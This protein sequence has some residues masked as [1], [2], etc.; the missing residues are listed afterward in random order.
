MMAGGAMAR[1]TSGRVTVP[2]T[3]RAGCAGR[4]GLAKT[5]L[6]HRMISRGRC[7]ISRF[8]SERGFVRKSAMAIETAATT[9]DAPSTSV[10]KSFLEKQDQVE[11]DPI[12]QLEISERYWRGMKKSK[13]TKGPTVVSRIHSDAPEEISRGKADF[14]VCVCGGNLG[15]AIALALQRRGHRVL[16]LER[17][18]LRGRK[19]EWNASRK[20]L[21]ALVSVGLL[22]EAE[23]EEAIVSEFNP[24]RVG[25]K[26]GE[27]VWVKDVLNIGVAP[28]RLIRSMKTRFIE[29]GGTVREL[30]EFRSAEIYDDMAVLKLKNLPPSKEDEAALT[31]SLDMIDANKP[32]AIPYE[33]SLDEEE[34]ILTEFNGPER[35]TCSL[36][37]DS[38]G[39]F[40]PIVKQLR[41]GTKP[42]SILLVVGGCIG[43]GIP[44]LGHSDVLA[45]ISG[46]ERDMQFFWETFPAKDGD[47]IYMFAY[48]DADESRLSFEDMLQSYLELIPRYCREG[49]KAEAKYF[50]READYGELA[51]ESLDMK[52]FLENLKFKRLLLG[53]FPSYKKAPLRSNI[54]RLVLVGDSSCVQ[55]P[56]SFGGFGAMLRHL[57]RLDQSLHEAIAG[58]HLTASDLSTVQPYMPSLSCAWLFQ[59]AMGYAPDQMGYTP[60][61]SELPKDREWTKDHINQVL[62]A[63]FAA[64]KNMDE[65]VL[66]SFLQDTIQFMPLTMT[67]GRMAFEDPVS[68]FRVIQRLGI[69]TLAEWIFHYFMLGLYSFLDFV[70]SRVGSS[71]M[72]TNFRVNRLRDAWRYG[73]GSDYE[74]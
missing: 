28:D 49:I 54:D 24:N 71:F 31:S 59:R 56:L 1:G 74:A 12:T 51:E 10:V 65:K 58:N 45:S 7:A 36:I 73:S 4:S 5:I 42:E 63:N 21:S 32:N 72:R 27:D 16:I 34:D 2:S 61:Y 52:A 8:G 23:L 6:R 17:R 48:A 33:S 60:N 29:N 22:T 37:I 53:A 64:M 26:G 46:S 68:V 15:I 13:A 25:F 55:S 3:V 41:S 43:E 35:V 11:G 50:G 57:P 67:M 38:M 18:L 44:K 14:D 66:L 47:T 19:Q 40:S 30:C 62:K 39:H 9:I 20:E 70:F 69:G